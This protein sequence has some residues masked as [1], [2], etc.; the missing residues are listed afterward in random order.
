MKKMDKS[1]AKI[2]RQKTFDLTLT[3]LELLH[4][5][6]LFSVLLPPDGNQ[7]MSKALAELE[8]R[9]LVE[10]M[11]WE[12]VSKLCEDADL[13]LADEAPDYILAPVSTPAIGIFHI[14]HD[15]SEEEQE[16]TE[17]SGFLPSAE[18]NESEEDDEAEEDE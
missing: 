3:K 8:G 12:K 17:E 9:R 15:M 13:P 2:K 18:G 11:L 6:D 1:S 16:A 5:R 7:T 4:I 10:T 14:N